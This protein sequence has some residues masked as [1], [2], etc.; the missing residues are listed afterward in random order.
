MRFS[1]AYASTLALS[2]ALLVKGSVTVYMCGDSTM[3]KGGAGDGDTDGWG[4]YLAQYI[5]RPVVNDAIGGRSARSYTREGRF[6]AVA[7]AVV[8]GDFVVIEFGHN[9]GGSL[10]PTDNGRTDCPGAGS[11]TCTSV[12]DGVTETVLTFP[13]YEIAAAKLMIAKG[14]HVIFS[15][16]TPDNPWETGVYVEPTTESR[17]TTYAR[18]G[19]ATTGQLFLD[20]GLYTYRAF[21]ALGYNIV[22]SYYPNGASSL[23]KCL[24]HLLI[25]HRWLG[26]QIIHTLALLAQMLWHVRL[27]GPWSA[28]ERPSLAM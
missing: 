2:G 14:A 9:D 12:Y 15:S 21:K 22:E 20:H 23:I 6:A 24:T 1:I 18:S 17:F 3:A 10:T 5:T 19:A 11:E 16:A 7:A 25:I 28:P 26:L 4:Q 13:A 27:S 8:Q